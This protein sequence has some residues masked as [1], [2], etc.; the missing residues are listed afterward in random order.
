MWCFA[1]HVTI[2]FSLMRIANIVRWWQSVGLSRW[3]LVIGCFS[4]TAALL[5][6]T[7]VV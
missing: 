7:R 6:W 5:L 1:G 4:A 3:W 2:L